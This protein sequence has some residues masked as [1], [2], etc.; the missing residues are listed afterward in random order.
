MV[1]K[2]LMG[3][4]IVRLNHLMILAKCFHGSFAILSAV[5]DFGLSCF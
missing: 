3:G 1:L 4:N 5:L 2:Q